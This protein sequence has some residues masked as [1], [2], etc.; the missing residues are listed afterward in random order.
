MDNVS[1]FTLA[2]LY[3]IVIFWLVVP[4]TSLVIFLAKIRVG[5]LIHKVE[6]YSGV[7]PVTSP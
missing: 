2:I 5:R 6:L 4:Y 3:L 7:E 1:Y